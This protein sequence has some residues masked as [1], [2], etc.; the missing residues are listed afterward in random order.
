MFSSVWNTT[1]KCCCCCVWNV[2]PCRRVLRTFRRI[3]MLPSLEWSNL[4]RED[5]CTLKMEELRCAETTLTT[6]RHGVTSSKPRNFIN[7][8]ARGLNFIF[9]VWFFL[10]LFQSVALFHSSSA[11]LSCFPVQLFDLCRYNT[12]AYISI[13]YVLQTNFTYDVF[14]LLKS[15][16]RCL[17]N[18]KINCP[19]ISIYVPGTMLRFNLITANYKLCGWLK[20][21]G[22]SR[23]AFCR[24]LHYLYRISALPVYIVYEY[25][26]TDVMRGK[27]FTENPGVRCRNITL[28]I[29]HV[30]RLLTFKSLTVVLFM[31]FG[32]SA[33]TTT[34]ITVFWDVRPCILVE[35]TDVSS[36]QHDVT[37]YTFLQPVFPLSSTRKLYSWPNKCHIHCL[38]FLFIW[39]APQSKAWLGPS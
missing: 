4:R 38:K 24:N 25:F 34:K 13:K 30:S 1:R 5:C 11:M 22:K 18:S 39:E 14:M 27:T 3:A 36:R 7:T 12:V 35:F 15:D 23:T 2:T 10:R 31:K 6:N 32:V 19:I 37:S 17:S 33:D 9:F 16:Q 8:A 28:Q 21:R 20:F 29:L 26:W